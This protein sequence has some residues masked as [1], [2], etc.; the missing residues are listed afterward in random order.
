MIGE[1][2]KNKNTARAESAHMWKKE[3][4]EGMWMDALRQE[5]EKQLLVG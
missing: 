4:D 5:R 2:L 3:K 1:I